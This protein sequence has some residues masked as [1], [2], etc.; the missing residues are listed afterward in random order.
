M[1]ETNTTPNSQ[2]HFSK[3][4]CVPDAI[5]QHKWQRELLNRIYVCDIETSSSVIFLHHSGS[6]VD[7]PCLASIGVPLHL[8][9]PGNERFLY[10]FISQA[11]DDEKLTLSSL[12]EE[13]FE[14]ILA[15]CRQFATES[16]PDG[17]TYSLT[18]EEE[19]QILKL[20]LWLS[21]CPALCHSI[22]EN[23]NI[24][25]LTPQPGKMLEHIYPFSENWNGYF[26]AG[27]IKTVALGDWEGPK[28]QAAVLEELWHAVDHVHK[29]SDTY[30][31][32][33]EGDILELRGLCEKLSKEAL[34]EGE[35]RE[36]HYMSIP[37]RFQ[38]QKTY[39]DLPL[40]QIQT[41]FLAKSAMVLSIRARELGSYADGLTEV[42]KS[43]LFAQSTFMMRLC[44]YMIDFRA[45]YSRSFSL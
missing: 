12:D 10:S 2:D 14:Q 35:L 8:V 11:Q 25:W 22:I 6:V 37:A 26:T 45:S 43:R 44:D 34:K 24:Y 38:D 36:L 17:Y 5:C 32:I 40:D 28:M 23:D 1:L 15:E 27:K 21:Q 39:K 3:F 20:Y 19:S 18:P 4:Q 16:R 42:K 30:F 9:A 29:L 31:R 33:T 7:I 13:T 41:E